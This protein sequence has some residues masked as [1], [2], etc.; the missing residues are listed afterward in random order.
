MSNV[1]HHPATC[2]KGHKLEGKNLLTMGDRNGR[3][4]WRCR[5]CANAYRKEYMRKKRAAMSAEQREKVLAY[6]REYHQR[7]EV[8][9]R[10]REYNQRPEVKERKR[11]F[12]R[13][14]ER[15]AAKLARDQRRRRLAAETRPKRVVVPK[16][17]KPKIPFEVHQ[18]WSQAKPGSMI[19][20]LFPRPQDLKKAVWDPETQTLRREAA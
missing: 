19:R 13:T 9:E 16:P 4:R 6:H 3:K 8:R 15:R 7:P 18:A 10:L 1:P 12:E 17:V 20:R 5:T 14:P 11:R 2:P